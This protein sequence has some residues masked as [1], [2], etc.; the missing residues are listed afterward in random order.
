MQ[1][2]SYQYAWLNNIYI[3][4][5]SGSLTYSSSGDLDAFI[6]RIF[7]ERNFSNILI[8]LS[9]T[10]SLD[11]TNL[12]LLAKIGRYTLDTFQRKTSMI[13]PRDDIN[14]V[15]RSMGFDSVFTIITEPEHFSGTLS[16]IP[17]TEQSERETAQTILDAHRTL[18]EMNDANRSVFKN[19]VKFL[20]KE[21]DSR[22]ANAH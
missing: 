22:D 5:L 13:S 6:S 19:V 7:A 11:S 17:H 21:I 14:R 16:S 15:L 12:G 2:G 1:S 10:D 20:E 8:D 4:K 9:E 3:I 18:M